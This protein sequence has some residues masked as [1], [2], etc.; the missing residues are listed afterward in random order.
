[1]DKKK[2]LEKEDLSQRNRAPVVNE[3]GRSAKPENQNQEH[4]TKK[5][6]LG[7]NTKR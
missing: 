6:S 5:V 2:T 4:N 3:R 1:M 7:P